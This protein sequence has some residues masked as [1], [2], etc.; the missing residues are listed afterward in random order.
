VPDRFRGKTATLRFE[1]SGDTIYLDNVFFKSQQLLLGNPT[2]A[3]ATDTA[4]NQYLNN[5]LLE[6]PQYSVSFSGDDH[7]LNWSAW[8][9][10]NSWFGTQDAGRDFRRDPKLDQLGI[11]SAK[12][13]DYDRPQATIDPGPT[14]S[15]GNFYKFE[16][17]HL[18]AYSDRK[19]STKDN[20]ATNLT[21]NIVPQQSE[22][23]SPLWSE[24]E[25]FSRK[26]VT[27]QGKEVYVYA[28]SVGEKILLLIKQ[29]YRLV[30]TQ[31]ME[32]MVFMFLIISGKF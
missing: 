14:N 17:G 3:R 30:E 27:N 32:V 1:S 15:A 7:I 8:Q 22:H 24:L 21:S 2:D 6:K 11:I 20:A 26:L 25:S 10:N 23:N 31:P 12:G 16:P 5:Y 29:T 9:L 18:A 4:S 19:R 28:G 13:S